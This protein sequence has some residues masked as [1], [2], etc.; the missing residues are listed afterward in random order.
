M[1]HRK[2]TFKVG[3]TASH[4]RALLANLAGSLILEGRILTSVTKAKEARRLV[5]RM[6][7]LGKRGTLSD[8]RRAIAILH[9]VSVVR[10]LFQEVAPRYA[11]RQGGYTRIIRL[12]PRRGDACDMCVLELVTEQ[13]A[14]AAG[15]GTEGGPAAEA[16]AAK[17]GAATAQ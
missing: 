2:H 10:K 14:P 9:Q 15:S 11:T 5:E 7:T 17:E 4:R 12:V 8:R 13:V 16:E 1:R 3:R 6:V